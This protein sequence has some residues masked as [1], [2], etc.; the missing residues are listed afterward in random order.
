[1]QKQSF[2]TIRQSSTKIDQA[3][4]QNLSKDVCRRIRQHFP[5]TFSDNFRQNFTKFFVKLCRKMSNAVFFWRKMMSKNVVECRQHFQTTFFDKVL[6]NLTNF[7]SNYVE[8]C[9]MMTKFPG[10]K[11]CRKLLTKN[12]VEKCC[13]IK[14]QQF[15]STNFY[16]KFLGLFV[17]YQTKIYSKNAV[18]LCKILSKFV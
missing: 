15:F 13:C 9:F 14:L 5:T 7:L 2:T 18:V 16:S 10:K 11:C 1:M 3:S 4:L 17:K 6:Q 12:V 8:I